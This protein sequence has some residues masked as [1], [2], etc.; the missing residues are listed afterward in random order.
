SRHVEA[1]A[2]FEIVGGAQGAVHVDQIAGDGDLGDR[3][4]DLAIL[5]DEARGAAAIVAGHRVDALADQLGHIEAAADSGEEVRHAL[6]AG[7]EMDVRGPRAGRTADAANGVAGRLE[8]E[9]PRRGAVEQPAGDTAALD[10]IARRGGDAFAVERARARA[11]A[12]V[13]V[14]TD[15]YVARE[16]L[17]R[18][19]VEQKAGAAGD[20]GAGHRADQ[21]ADQAG[22]DARVEDHRHGAARGL[23]RIEALHRTL[24]GAQAEG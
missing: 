3:P 7:F 8:P 24:R 23:A 10:E 15:D 9:L 13:G 21:M 11:A 1:A 12:A 17:F 19:P 5:D 22:A 16:Q 20:G 6:A 14:L 4:G 2:E 18:E